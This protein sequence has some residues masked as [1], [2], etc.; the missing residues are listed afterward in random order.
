VRPWR[1]TA[2]GETVT[3]SLYAALDG[4][5]LADE[6]RVGYERSQFRHWIDADSD[7]CNTRKETILAE[8]VTAPEVGTRC[9]LTGGSWFSLY[10]SVPVDDAAGLDVDHMVPLAEAWDSGA[11]SWTVAERQAYAN[12]LGDPSSLIAVSARSNRQRPIRTLR[13]GCLSRTTCAPTSPTGS[14]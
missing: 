8:A 3:T 2:P 1:R 11:S 4:L 9:S 14:R 12:D 5:P 6:S 13:T 7:G 10:D